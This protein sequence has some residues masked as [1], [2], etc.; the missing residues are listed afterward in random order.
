ML[1]VPVGVDVVD[2]HVLGL[3]QADARFLDHNLVNLRQVGGRQTAFFLTL[4]L[5]GADH[6]GQRRF[7]VEQ[8]PGDIHED[9]VIGC[10]L[11]LGEAQDHRQLVNDDL[12]RLTE[13][14]HR[15]GVGDL[16]Q[17][18]QQAVEIGSVLTIAAHEQVQ[19]LLDPHQ[20]LAQRRQYRTHGVAVRPCQSCT[21]LIDHCAVRQRVI[22]SVAIFHGQHLP[23]GVFGFGYVEQQTLEQLRRRR[24]IDGGH[25]LFEQAL[26]FFVGFLEQAAQGR[27]VGNRTGAHAFDQR[28]SDLPQRAQGC[29][30]AQA[31]KATEYFGQITEVGLV[32]LLAE[33]ADQGHLQHLP[34]F[35]QHARQVRRFQMRQRRFVQRRQIGQQRAEQAGFRQQAFATGAAQVVDQRQ[36]HQRQVASRTLNPVE[37]DRQ[38]PQGLH[39]QVQRLVTM[40][41]A[42][43]LQGAY[44]LLHLFG[45]Q[46]RAVEFDHLQTAVNLMNA[47]QAIAQR[48]R[49]LRIIQQGFDGVMSLLQRFGNLAFDPFEGHIVV[50]ITH[51]HLSYH[52]S[53]N[54]NA[55]RRFKLCPSPA[56]WRPAR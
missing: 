49:R 51:N 50:P 55:R 27:A 45:E 18:R 6:A 9:R 5:H 3:L 11:A 17:R 37:V 24:L 41:D 12:A 52:F 25:A 48:V 40:A 2:D 54:A 8:G 53:Q 31:F 56:P 4:R 44:K 21:F 47:R 34:Q 19:A 7:D 30:T 22:Q 14:Q 43:L 16:P 32:I 13:T 20:L 33:Q 23:G 29:V 15:Q 39:Q 42:A 36:H 1:T 10:A 35:A 38:L 26:E 46:G 28:R